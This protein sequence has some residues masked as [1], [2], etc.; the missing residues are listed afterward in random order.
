MRQIITII[1]ITYV[2]KN[3]QMQTLFNQLLTKYLFFFFF[4]RNGPKFHLQKLLIFKVQLEINRP[5]ASNPINL[6]A[7]TC[8]DPTFSFLAVVSPYGSG[9]GVLN[10]YVQP[11]WAAYPRTH[12]SNKYPPVMGTQM[13]CM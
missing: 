11:I 5:T 7:G 9:G 6:M 3:F 10:L 12:L 8:K 1:C 2:Q 4:L 13:G